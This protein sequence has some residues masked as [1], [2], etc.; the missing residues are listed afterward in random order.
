[1]PCI[2]RGRRDA[3]GSR[4]RSHPQECCFKHAV[5]PSRVFVK[6]TD[7]LKDDGS[8]QRF[9]RR[10][11]QIATRRD[12]A[13]LYRLLSP[14]FFEVGCCEDGP[15]YKGLPAIASFKAM[16]AQ[17]PN[18]QWPLLGQALQVGVVKTKRTYDG[19][20]SPNG[21]L[22]CGPATA[23]GAL[24]GCDFGPDQSAGDDMAYVIG[25][26]VPLH[27]EPHHSARIIA[28]LSWDM[29]Q[30]LSDGWDRWTKVRLGNGTTGYVES[31]FVHWFLGP[32]ICFRK[33]STGPWRIAGIDLG[34]D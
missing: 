3:V 10:L 11:A 15:N 1:M 31:R 28:S 26:S 13:A 20:S 29:V 30:A 17:E 14:K 16:V 5:V 32:T 8:F 12:A 19:Y 18:S 22:F 34:G 9:K 24:S 33:D 2:P 25:T 27:A 6:P 23:S 4:G 21:L 7:D